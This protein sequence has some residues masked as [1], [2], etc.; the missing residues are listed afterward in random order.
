VVAYDNE[1]TAAADAV[2]AQA[3][4]ASKDYYLAAEIHITDVFGPGDYFI[5]V[6]GH[7]PT[8]SGIFAHASQN[9]PDLGTKVRELAP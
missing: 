8:P 3:L 7:P 1:V 6:K 5:W 2:L 9:Y 4:S